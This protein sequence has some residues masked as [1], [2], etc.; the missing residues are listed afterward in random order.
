MVTSS[1]SW[2]SKWT[3]LPT[4]QSE[5]VRITTSETASPTSIAKANKEIPIRIV[6][7]YVAGWRLR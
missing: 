2:P 5:F 3:S 6:I 4:K 7:F 1:L